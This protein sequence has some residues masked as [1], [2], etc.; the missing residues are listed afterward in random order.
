VNMH[1]EI[2]D[3]VEVKPS[4]SFPVHACMGTCPSLPESTIMY[5]RSEPPR[6]RSVRRTNSLTP[7]SRQPKLEQSQRCS[8]HASTK[9]VPNRQL[10]M[11]DHSQCK[12]WPSST[13]ARPPATST[14]P[15]SHHLSHGRCTPTTS[16]P[17]VA[18]R[19]LQVLTIDIL[20]I[21]CISG[22]RFSGFSFLRN[23][24]C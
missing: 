11:E 20:F 14:H 7:S 1:N 19:F 16:D 23:S 17:S 15:L 22:T 5:P 18:P 8:P 10:H 24:G 12:F 6:D 4:L 2:K 3:C 9:P 21:E 13:A